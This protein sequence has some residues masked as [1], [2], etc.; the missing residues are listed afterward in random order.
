MI[1]FRD[2]GSDGT[3]QDIQDM[4]VQAIRDAIDELDELFGNGTRTSPSIT[5]VVAQKDHNMRIVP[6]RR[7]DAVRGNVPSGTLVDDYL[8]AY[9]SSENENNAFD[10]LLTPQGGL[11]GTSKPMHYRVLLNEN[12]NAAKPLTK[13]ILY[14]IVYAMSF[15]CESAPK[16]KCAE[17]SRSSGNLSHSLLFHL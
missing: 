5:F 10:F 17:Y 2:G 6:H 13:Q 3:F 14:N 1:V 15:Q 16:Q 4:E 9:Q 12:A 7:D 11:K 8:T